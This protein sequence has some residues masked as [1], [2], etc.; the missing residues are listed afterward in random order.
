MQFRFGR[1]FTASFVAV[2]AFYPLVWA[3]MCANL[4]MLCMKKWEYV[5]LLHPSR[6]YPV[7]AIFELHVKN[8]N[9]YA[10]ESLLWAFTLQKHSVQMFGTH[11]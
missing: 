2:A 10:V 4:A 9:K 11:A 1:G 8:S 3:W 7:H 5:T 6:P